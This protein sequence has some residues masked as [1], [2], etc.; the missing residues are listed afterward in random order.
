M[1]FETGYKQTLA[2]KLNPGDTSM[3]VDVAPT[4]TAWRVYLKSGSQEEWISFSGVSGKTLTG[5]Q[6]QLSKTSNPATS[7]G[8]GFTWIAWTPV[9]IVAMHDQITD[10]QELLNANNTFNGDNT[11]TGKTTLTGDFDVEWDLEIK[12]TGTLVINWQSIP[13]PI[14][15]TTTARD[16]LYTNPSGWEAA[17][18]QAL[19]ALQIYNGWSS[20]WES[21]DVWTPTP[22]ATT[23]SYGT[24][25]LATDT[26]VNT[27][28]GVGV[29]QAQQWIIA[30]TN[31][32]FK[33]VSGDFTIDYAELTYGT[34]PDNDFE[35]SAWT[36]LK[37]GMEYVVRVYTQSTVYNMTLGTGITNP[38]GE[39]IEFKANK[40]TTMVFFATSDSTLELWAIRTAL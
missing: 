20:Q 38:F 33:T 24:V 4:I 3:L 2:A 16:A 15:A 26:E 39:V 19:N 31:T 18:V 37:A 23:S 27:G 14:V 28:A 32:L 30:Y 13:Y 6:R 36:H 29:V 17:Y 34:T 35:V 5:L 22:Q 7:Q 8:S 25:R 1:V 10:L 12:N 40:D 21:L 9:R 11:F